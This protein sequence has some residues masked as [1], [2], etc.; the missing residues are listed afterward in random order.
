MDFIPA[1]SI[2]G[3][4]VFN[5]EADFKTPPTPGFFTRDIS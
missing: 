3:P 5:G 2:T 4:V 1:E